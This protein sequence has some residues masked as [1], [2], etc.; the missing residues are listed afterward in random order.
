MRFLLKTSDNDK[1]NDYI[2][3]LVE[4]ITI[5]SHNS[6]SPKHKIQVKKISDYICD[7]LGGKGAFREFSDLIIKSK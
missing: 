1:L 3:M 6:E 7:T 4:Q 2:G 5:A